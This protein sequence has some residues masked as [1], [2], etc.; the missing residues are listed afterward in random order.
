M[1]EIKERIEK[2]SKRVRDSIQAELH[3]RSLFRDIRVD[4]SMSEAVSCLFFFYNGPPSDEA[5]L[6]IKSRSISV[7]VFSFKSGRVV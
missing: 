5:G 7:A 1:Y 2:K 3:L 4:S 6:F